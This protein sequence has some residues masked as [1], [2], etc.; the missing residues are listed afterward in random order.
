MADWAVGLIV[1]A[2]GGSVVLATIALVF[3]VTEWVEGKGK[4]GMA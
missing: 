4:G 1:V 3:W 2:I